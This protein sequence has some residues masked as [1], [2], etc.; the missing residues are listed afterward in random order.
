MQDICSVQ[1][2]MDSCRG[3]GDNHMK[4]FSKCKQSQRWGEKKKTE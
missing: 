3:K 4:M 1:P 2:K